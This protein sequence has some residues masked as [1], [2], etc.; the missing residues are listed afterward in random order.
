MVFEKKLHV[1]RMKTQPHSKVYCRLGISV[2][3]MAASPLI[4]AADP[5]PPSGR[6]LASQCFQCHT[7]TAGGT[8]GFESI[9]GIKATEMV[10]KLKEM[11]AKAKPENIME[12]HSKGYTDAQ[13]L[14][15]AAYLATL[16]ETKDDSAAR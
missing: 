10:K 15:L 1:I 5:L 3:I 16:P 6:L 4:L 13:I 12:R 2:G 11:R 7:V 9:T 8:G 14:K